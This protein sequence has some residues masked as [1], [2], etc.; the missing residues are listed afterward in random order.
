MKGGYHVDPCIAAPGA[1]K[2]V[3]DLLLFASMAYLRQQGVSYLS[4]GYEPSESLAGISG[5]QGPLA[6][7]TDR[8]YQFTFHRLP[9]SGKRAYF[10]KFRPDDAQSEPVY[11]IFPSKL[12]RPR[13]VLA[14]A[15]AA[16]I[17]LRRL[18]FYGSPRS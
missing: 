2:G 17:R 6:P 8:L 13:D 14:V 1:R 15:H 11:L 4:V 12:P 18:V 5:L 16:N 3:T 10:D 7:L 9:I